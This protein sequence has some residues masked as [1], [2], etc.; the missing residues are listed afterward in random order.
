[1]A[2]SRFL[3]PCTLLTTSLSKM[4]RVK[5]SEP[6][7][8]GTRSDARARCHLMAHNPGVSLNHEIVCALRVHLDPQMVTWDIEG[9]RSIIDDVVNERLH[10]IAWEKKSA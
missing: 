8:L 4:A 6:T 5:P 10:E 2:K 1:M 3:A 9:I 7:S